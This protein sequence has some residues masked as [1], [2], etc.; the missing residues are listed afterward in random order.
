MPVRE[1]FALGCHVIEKIPKSK[2]DKLVKMML[3]GASEIAG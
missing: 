1:K 2:L 3:L